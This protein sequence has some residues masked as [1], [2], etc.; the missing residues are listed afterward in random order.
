[1]LL[2]RFD[3]DAKAKKPVYSKHED[4]LLTASKPKIAVQKSAKQGLSRGIASLIGTNCQLLALS[5]F[6]PQSDLKLY[7]SLTSRTFLPG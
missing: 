6:Q 5:L 4:L 3:S 2:V 7:T 1:M